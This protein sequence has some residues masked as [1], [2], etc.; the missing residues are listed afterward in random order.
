MPDE[1]SSQIKRILEVNQLL[2][3]PARLAILLFL[4][5][6]DKATFNDV[7]AALGLTPGNLSSHSKKLQAAGLL[8]I[9]KVF[10]NAKPTTL[11]V[12]TDQGKRATAE[13]AAI[14]RQALDQIED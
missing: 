2:H 11:L 10:V 12:I 7:Q 8:K 13:Y 1:D 4:L 3:S 5:H 9:G 14:L 6:R